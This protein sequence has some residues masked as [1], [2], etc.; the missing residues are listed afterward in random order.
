MAFASSG[1]VFIL[2]SMNYFTV[3]IRCGLARTGS[4]GMMIHSIPL[5]M[6][7]GC[8]NVRFLL[9]AF[10]ST[11]QQA[12]IKIHLTEKKPCLTL[13]SAWKKP[14]IVALYIISHQ[15]WHNNKP[16]MGT[17]NHYFISLL[18]FFCVIT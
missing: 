2:H 13:G 14:N 6:Y 9:E 5:H 11:R 7:G 10:Y 3:Y 17:F 8:I 4:L 18:Q 15:T 16:A 1:M 12:S